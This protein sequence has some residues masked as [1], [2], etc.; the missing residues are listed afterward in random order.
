MSKKSPIDV[1][2]EIRKILEQDSRYAYE[3]Y[4]FV[5]EALDFTLNLRKMKGHVRGQELLEGIRRFA[6]EQFGPMTLTV[7][8]RWGLHRTEDFGEIVFKMVDSGI[9]GKTD[10]D[11]K[12]DFAN[13]YDFQETFGK[14]LTLDT[15][16]PL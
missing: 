16:F 9:L 11:S 4:H 7:F 12:D 6:L 14:P 10:E 13:G 5:R 1:E 3:V 2:Q 8:D 15:D